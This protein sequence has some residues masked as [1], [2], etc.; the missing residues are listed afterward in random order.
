LNLFYGNIYS[1]LG[2]YPAACGVIPAKAGIQKL[3]ASERWHDK[4]PRGLPRGHSFLRFS[5]MHCH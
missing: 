1:L 3:D 5:V 2:K 4:I